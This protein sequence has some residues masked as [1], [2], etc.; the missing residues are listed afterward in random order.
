MGSTLLVSRMVAYFSLTLE[1]VPE[2]Y[3]SL[4]TCLFRMG[5]EGK[6]TLG[7]LNHRGLAYPT[8][9]GECA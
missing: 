1:E 4:V 7:I 9:L 3:L 2:Q 6:S 5:D 8:S